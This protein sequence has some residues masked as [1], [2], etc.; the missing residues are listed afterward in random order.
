M[1]LNV[2]LIMFF[3]IYWFSNF[4]FPR[5]LIQMILFRLWAL[6]LTYLDCLSYLLFQI[7]YSL[8]IRSN[9]LLI[10]VRIFR[11]FCYIHC[12]LISTRLFRSCSLFDLLINLSIWVLKARCFILAAIVF[13]NIKM[14]KI[15]STR[16][17]SFFLWLKT[18]T[19]FFIYQLL[20]CIL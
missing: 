1:F 2:L 17:L 10:W 7:I 20:N 6:I 19:P 12:F 11:W 14:L 3:I 8:W 4:M 5:W 16:L 13:R 9:W 15:S 18:L